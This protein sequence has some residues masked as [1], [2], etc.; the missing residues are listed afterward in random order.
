MHTLQVIIGST[1]PTRAADQVARWVMD[2][3]RRH[4]DLRPELLDLRE[5]PLP[6]F[7]EHF[8]TIG[9]FADLTYSDPMVRSWNAKIREGATPHVR[10]YAPPPVRG[11]AG[12]DVGSGQRG[13]V[14]ARSGVMR[15]AT[16]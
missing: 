10:G 11:A 2:R 4:P 3:A 9:D 12:R 13:I 8:G 1:R 16:P 14:Q 5:W 6:M 7:G 15:R